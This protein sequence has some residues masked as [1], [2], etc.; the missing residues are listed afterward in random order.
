MNMV[1]GS[2]VDPIIEGKINGCI[3]GNAVSWELEMEVSS[4]GEKIECIVG[5]S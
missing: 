2:E 1:I 5:C 4:V 3:V